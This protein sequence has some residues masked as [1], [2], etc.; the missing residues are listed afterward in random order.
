MNFDEA[1]QWAMD[2]EVIICFED[3]KNDVVIVFRK[4]DNHCAIKKEAFYDRFVDNFFIPIIT[5]LKKK[6]GKEKE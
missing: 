6:V 5:A 2:N 4:E 1:I 3:F